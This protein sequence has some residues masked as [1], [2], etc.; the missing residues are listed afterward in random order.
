M[1]KTVEN[2]ELLFG[3]LLGQLAGDERLLPSHMGLVMA[4]YGQCAG[5]SG[6]SFNASRRKLMH[7]SRIRST[8][9]YHKCLSELVEYGYLEYLPSWHPKEASR[10]RFTFEQERGNNGKG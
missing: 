3:K 10:F 8:S 1:A 6:A 7:A 2:T 5:Q 9:T 4:L